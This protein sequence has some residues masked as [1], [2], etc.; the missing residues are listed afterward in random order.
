MRASRRTAT[1]T[2][3]RILAKHIYDFLTLGPVAI[4]QG[5]GDE[6]QARRNLQRS[7]CGDFAAVRPRGGCEE[8]EGFSPEVSLIT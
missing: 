4:S 2:D 6:E 5:R 8:L 3:N 1:P 7:D